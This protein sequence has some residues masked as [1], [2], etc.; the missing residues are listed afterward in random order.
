MCLAGRPQRLQDR[1][2]QPEGQQP[3]EAMK[4][5]YCSLE[6]SVRF[7]VPCLRPPLLN[8]SPETLIYRGCSVVL[9][10]F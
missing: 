7:S 8:P 2:S 6:R 4:L 10:T 5:L 1:V 3:D 9:W